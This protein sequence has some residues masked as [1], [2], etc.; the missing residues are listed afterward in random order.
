MQRDVVLACRDVVQLFPSAAGTVVALRGVDAE[1]AAGTI[2]VVVGPSGAGKSTLLRVLAGLDPPAA[3]D[4]WID[5]RPTAHLRGR[6]R[7]RLI[8]GVVGYVHQRPGENLLDYLTV[9]QHVALAW[10]LRG[11]APDRAARDDLLAR[12]GLEDH[13]RV[14]P[15]DLSFGEQQRLAFAMAVAGAPSVV[16]ADEPTSQLDDRETTALVDAVT[17]LARLGQAF[18]IASHDQPVMAAAD[19]TISIEAGRV[20]TGRAAAD[21]TAE[22]VIDPAGRILLPDEARQLFA[23]NRVAMT[24]TADEVRLHRP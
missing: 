22:A 2:T 15:R 5:G 19:T 13:A 20:G 6:R 21:V 12:T 7:R 23:G 11:L 1:F 16:I 8:A 24:V 3:G 4:V 18:I 14:K 10:R 17:R 9:A